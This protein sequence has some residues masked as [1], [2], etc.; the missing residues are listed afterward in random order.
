MKR[1]KVKNV[2]AYSLWGNDRKYTVGALRN[3][4]LAEEI[5]PGWTSVFF[6]G[7]STSRSVVDALSHQPNTQVVTMDRTG[8]WTSLFWRFLPCSDSDVGIVLSRDADSRLSWRERAAVDQW[9]SSELP[10]HIMRDH[11]SHAAPILGGMWG[12]RAPL[13]RNMETLIRNYAKDSYWQVDQDFLKD[14]V[15]P[16]VVRKAM[17]H[18]DFFDKAPFPAKRHGCE[19]VGEPFDGNDQPDREA[20]LAL[21]DFQNAPRRLKKIK[22][23]LFGDWLRAIR[24]R[25]RSR[26]AERSP[27]LRQTGRHEDCSCPRRKLARSR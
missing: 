9:L 19:F 18:D 14:I 23:S 24:T 1:V 21:R 12:C 7:A 13:L 20:R 17:V 27:Q 8:D 4:Q 25:H 26:A 10:F 3:A 2:I 11:P 5:F 6:V 15:Y 16:L 22:R